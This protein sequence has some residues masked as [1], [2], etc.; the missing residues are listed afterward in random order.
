MGPTP[1]LHR[2]GNPLEFQN[3][4]SWLPLAFY[5][6]RHTELSMWSKADADVFFQTGAW[7]FQIWW[8]LLFCLML[9]PSLSTLARVPRE[10]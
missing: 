10:A 9:T 8:F 5:D 7:E 1:D 2:D 4:D 6:V 3:A